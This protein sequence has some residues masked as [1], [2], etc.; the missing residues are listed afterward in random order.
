VSYEAFRYRDYRLYQT[1]R[2][3]NTVAIQMQS[4]AVGWHVYDLTHRPLDLGYVG[5][6]QFLPMLSLSLVA[7]HTAD[8]FDRQRVYRICVLGLAT[9]SLLLYAAARF[10]VANIATIYGILV[11]YGIVRAF[12]GPS[13]SA[14]LT[15][16]VPISVFPNA[17]AWSSTVWQIAA[18]SGPAL[19]GAIYGI[20][21][22]P[23]AVY[24]TS[25]AL[26]LV[27]FTILGAMDVRTGRMETRTA[28]LETVFAGVR[29]IFRHKVILGS[30][31]LDLFAV[32]LGGAVALLPIFARDIL[33]AGPRGLGL[34]RS[35]P[36]FG[37][38]T[39][40]LLVAYRPIQ[41][42]AGVTMLACVFLF[43]VATV[44]FSLSRVFALSLAALYLVGAT[45]MVSVLVRS[46]L[47]QVT[48]PPEM[49]GR[50]SAVNQLFIG[51]SNELGEFESG[52]TAAAFGAVRA[53]FLGG[54]ATCAVVAIWAWRFPALRRVDRIDR[55]AEG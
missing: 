10:G 22:R 6:V 50:V 48:T 1:S 35:A 8:R 19:G 5:L 17:V 23:V 25:G 14:L 38:A 16:V 13:G 26:T 52:V 42:R 41:R 40:A 21:G 30:I 45:D 28:S 33:H 24:A 34:L 3:L 32:L 15:H 4:V 2:F 27:S 39:T 46:T 9:C 36:A 37:A 31:S 20:S 53:A 12:Y 29:Y 51:A 18:I 55:P 11:F 49:R 7:G 47:I 43:G 44:V 54:I